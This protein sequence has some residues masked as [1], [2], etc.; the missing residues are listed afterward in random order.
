MGG[1]MGKQEFIFQELCERIAK[2]IKIEKINVR[3]GESI[4]IIAGIGK[5]KNE[6]MNG[7]YLFGLAICE[8]KIVEGFTALF[9]NEEEMKQLAKK[10]YVPTLFFPDFVATALGYES[11]LSLVWE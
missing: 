1:I 10:E 7:K 4:I 2:F 9:K 5:D 3:V 6:K 8:G 11:T